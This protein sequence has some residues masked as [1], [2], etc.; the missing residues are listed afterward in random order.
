[1]CTGSSTEGGGSAE[2]GVEQGCLGIGRGSVAAAR[3]TG[4]GSGGYGE[5]LA[6]RAR[7]MREREREWVRKKLERGGREAWAR[8]VLF[9]GRGEEEKSRGGRENGG[10]HHNAIDGVAL[11]MTVTSLKERGVGRGKRICS[12]R[13]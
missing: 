9:I 10:G 1:V 8:P 4:R 5:A 3:R 7:P 13:G 2:H 12:W 11:T 6:N